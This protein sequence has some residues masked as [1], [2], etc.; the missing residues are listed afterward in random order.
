MGKVG[1]SGE[2]KPPCSPSWWSI[3]WPAMWIKAPKNKGLGQ[4]PKLDSFC[5][6]IGSFNSNF[7]HTTWLHDLCSSW[8]A[9]LSRTVYNE[10]TH[11]AVCMFC[12]TV[13]ASDG[14]TAHSRP[15][16]D[17]GL[18]IPDPKCAS[19]EYFFSINEKK[20]SD[21]MQTL[22]TGCSKAEPKKISPHRRPPSR[23]QG[24]AKI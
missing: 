13:L 24:T 14:T 16:N 2:W 7:V 15:C 1:Q 12:T 23:G 18:Q 17:E 9:K 5:Y 11:L 4:S 21:E 8:R 20:R 10:A 22:H 6:L 19:L 3:W